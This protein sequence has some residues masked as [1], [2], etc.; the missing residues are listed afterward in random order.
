VERRK[1]G[2]KKAPSEASPAFLRAIKEWRELEDETL[3]ISGE[4]IERSRNPIVRIIME[5]IRHDSEKHKVLLRLLEEGLTKE[6]LHLSPEELSPLADM[7]ERH[8]EAE[9]KSVE[10]ARLALE[11]SELFV[12]RYLLT[13]LLADEAK[14]HRLLEDL[15]E[16]IIKRASIFVM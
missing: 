2:G 9:T 5:M 6:E 8:I 13:M 15:N 10:A 11:E 1:R 14:H 7:I 4:T 16:I 3:Q 12:T